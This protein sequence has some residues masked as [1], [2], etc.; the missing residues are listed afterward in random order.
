MGHREPETATFELEQLESDLW[1]VEYKNKIIREIHS[2]KFQPLLTATVDPQLRYNISWMDLPQ[3]S[4]QADL[5]NLMNAQLSNARYSGMVDQL[6][7]VVEYN[8]EKR[9]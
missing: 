2:L 5:L 8:V 3:K 1:A 4:M 9:L 6:V 7:R